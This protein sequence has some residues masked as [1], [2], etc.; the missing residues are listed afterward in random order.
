[1]HLHPTVERSINEYMTENLEAI[2]DGEEIRVEPKDGL[3]IAEHCIKAMEANG[4]IVQP[5]VRFVPRPPAPVI[6]AEARALAEQAEIP[7]KFTRAPWQWR[8]ER[9]RFQL[10]VR[11][12]PIS[13]VLS[14]AT[15]LYIPDANLIAQAPELYA[16]LAEFYDATWDAGDYSLPLTL[17]GRALAALKR[18]RG[19]A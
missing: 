3:S 5:T 14:N 8:S 16:L 11:D 6:S 13:Q 17:R 7:T 10:V 18:A 19:E 2:I 1:M 12:C 15:G 9:K 4:F